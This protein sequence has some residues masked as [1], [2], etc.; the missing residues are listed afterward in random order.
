MVDG[1]GRRRF[2]RFLVWSL[3]VAVVTV[4]GV[5]LPLPHPHG[6]E[7]LLEQAR[8]MD[9][10]TRRSSAQGESEVRGLVEERGEVAWVVS[11]GQNLRHR[12]FVRSDVV[13]CSL[14]SRAPH[15]EVL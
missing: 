1:A 3:V 8:T 14:H 5:P 11:M 10:V 9:I 6:E 2:L 13:P 4:R 7:G 15:Q 12:A